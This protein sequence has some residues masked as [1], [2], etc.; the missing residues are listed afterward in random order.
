MPTM[1]EAMTRL[2]EAPVIDLADLSVLTG[3]SMST[4]H[5]KVNSGEFPI[6]A[7]RL[8]QRW[9]IPTSAV[10]EWLKVAI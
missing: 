5:R 10:R 7:T 8:G 1:S 3:V 6:H 4:V 9:I 2:R